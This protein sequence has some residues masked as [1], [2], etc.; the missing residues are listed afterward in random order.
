MHRQCKGS[1][2]P[3]TMKTASVQQ[4]KHAARASLPSYLQCQTTRSPPHVDPDHTQYN[5]GYRSRPTNRP[6][7]R[8]NFRI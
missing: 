8:C 7:S 1:K 2:T 3:S 4:H 6:E 5:V